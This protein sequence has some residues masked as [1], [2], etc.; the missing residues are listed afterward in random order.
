LSF[1]HER[2]GDPPDLI[3]LG[4]NVGHLVGQPLQRLHDLASLEHRQGAQPTDPQR[5]QRQYCH[6]AR[7]G[8]RARH[9]DLGAGVQ[10]R[11]AVH[12][13]G[14][15]ASHDVHDAEGARSPLLGLAYRRQRV[16]RLS[17]L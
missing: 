8:L 3:G 15:G 5:E 6:L 17:A 1:A 12:L 10:I 9:A 7:E 4:Q 16:G 13:P 14:N 2:L 11:P